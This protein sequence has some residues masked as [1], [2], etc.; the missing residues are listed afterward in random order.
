MTSIEC[1][2]RK[3]ASQHVHL[4]FSRDSTTL[5][6]SDDDLGCEGLEWQIRNHRRF[7]NGWGITSPMRSSVQEQEI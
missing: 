6:R 3:I 2:C 4:K 7:K 5:D 1:E